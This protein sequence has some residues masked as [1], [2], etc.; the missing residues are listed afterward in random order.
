MK[1]FNAI[2]ALAAAGSVFATPT[3]TEELVARASSTL[4]PITVQGN[5]TEVQHR[6]LDSN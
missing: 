4:T 2:A 6:Y 1:T 5:G 3:P